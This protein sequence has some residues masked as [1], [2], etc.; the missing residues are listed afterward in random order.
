MYQ[1]LH[2]NTT[3]MKASNQCDQLAGLFFQ[4]LAIYNIEQLPNSIDFLPK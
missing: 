3:V 1:I 4:Y 2:E